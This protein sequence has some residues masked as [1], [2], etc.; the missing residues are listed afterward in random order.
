[1][2]EDTSAQRSH[3]CVW[4]SVRSQK[5]RKGAYPRA[6]QR[7]S[8]EFSRRKDRTLHWGQARQ[9]ENWDSCQW[10]NQES[11][12]RRQTWYSRHDRGSS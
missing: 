6:D 12:S 10:W 9:R 3:H 2:H 11:L 7:I 8:A 4:R 1:V 5:H